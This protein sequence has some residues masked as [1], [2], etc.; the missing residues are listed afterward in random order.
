MN[1]A[2][3]RHT[4][5]QHWVR[6]VAVLIGLTVWGMLMPIIYATRSQTRSTSDSTCDE[7]KIVRPE[8]RRASSRS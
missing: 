5:R 2:V 1:L 3:F 6:L 7:K 8:P 4:V